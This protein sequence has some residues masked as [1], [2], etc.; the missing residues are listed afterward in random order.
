MHAGVGVL[1]RH[2]GVLSILQPQHASQRQVSPDFTTRPTLTPL[3]FIICM[4]AKPM[5]FLGLLPIYPSSTSFLKNTTGNHILGLI[6]LPT[7]NTLSLRVQV[8]IWLRPLC[9]LG[10]GQSDGS[11]WLPAVLL[12]LQRHPRAAILPPITA[13]HI[14]GVRVNPA[15]SQQ[16]LKQR[17]SDTFGSTSEYFPSQIKPASFRL[18]S[19]FGAR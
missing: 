13:V 14:Q 8:R 16:P 4:N 12:L 18:S 19:G 17:A 10:G 1:V 6:F 2:T 11:G 15:P 9:G 7:K 3:F 5:L